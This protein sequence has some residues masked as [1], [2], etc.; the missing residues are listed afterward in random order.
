MIDVTR[1]QPPSRHRPALLVLAA[2]LWLTLAGCTSTPQ[3]ARASAG[4]IDI[5]DHIGQTTPTRAAVIGAAA[6][7]LGRPYRANAAGP[8]AFSDNGLVTYA[9]GHVGVALPM[10]P[11][12]LLGAGPPILMN[13]AE[14][15][16]LVFFQTHAAGGADSLRVGL[17]LNNA[18]MLYASADQGHVVIQPIDGTYWRGRLLG[19]VKVLP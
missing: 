1:K 12:G 18:E 16:D 8:A 17:Y 5:L 14:P 11:H 13:Q 19:L 9:Y 3:Q 6:D 2:L 4:T 15:G 7:M 10:A